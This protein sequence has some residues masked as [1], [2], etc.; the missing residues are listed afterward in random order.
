MAAATTLSGEAAVGFL[1]LTKYAYLESMTYL[2]LLVDKN[3][4]T[5]TE[6]LEKK[7]TS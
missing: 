6:Y 1:E 4:I 2:N 3:V 7:E 5:E